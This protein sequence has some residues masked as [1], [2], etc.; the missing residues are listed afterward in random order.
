MDTITETE[1]DI[2]QEDHTVVD[3]VDMVA[4]IVIAEDQDLLEDTR[5]GK[6]EVEVDLETKVKTEKRK[7]DIDPD[8]DDSLIH[9]YINNK[10]ISMS[11]IVYY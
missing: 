3:T 10:F 6:E 2:D 5:E 1:V 7:K 8:P 4:E 11:Y 9:K